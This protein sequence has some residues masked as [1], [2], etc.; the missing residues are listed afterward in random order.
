MVIHVQVRVMVIHLQ[1]KFK[2]LQ[3]QVIYIILQLQNMIKTTVGAD[4]YHKSIGACNGNKIKCS[5]NGH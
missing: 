4:N 3:V 2:Q 5:G 1:D